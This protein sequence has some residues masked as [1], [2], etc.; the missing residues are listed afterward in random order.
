[1]KMLPRGA[2]DVKVVDKQGGGGGRL[3]TFWT[4]R[5]GG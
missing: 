2:T 3:L 1:M 4:F 5:V